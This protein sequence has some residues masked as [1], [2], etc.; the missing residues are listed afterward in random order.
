LIRR[1][2]PV[3]ALAVTINQDFLILLS[4]HMKRRRAISSRSTRRLRDRAETIDGLLAR[5]CAKLDPEFE[6][7]LADEGLAQ[8][9]RQWPPFEAAMSSEQDSIDL[10]DGS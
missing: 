6:Q 1:C 9:L 5:E 4:R 2:L 3:A 10:T 7:Q 8:D